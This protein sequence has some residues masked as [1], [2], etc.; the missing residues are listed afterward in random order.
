MADALRFNDNQEIGFIP[1]YF[2]VRFDTNTV[3][4]ADKTIARHIKG[5]HEGFQ[6]SISLG[7]AETRKGAPEDRDLR[8][9]FMQNFENYYRL[10]AYKIAMSRRIKMLGEIVHSPEFVEKAGKYGAWYAQTFITMMAR[11]GAPRQ[12]Q[13]WERLDKYRRQAARGI[14]P[15][16]PATSAIHLTLI[17]NVASISGPRAAFGGLAKAMKPGMKGFRPTFGAEYEEWALKNFATYRQDHGN[18]PIFSDF[19]TQARE[20]WFS[21]P[22]SLRFIV[23][24]ATLAALIGNYEKFIREHNLPFDPEYPGAKTPKDEREARDEDGLQGGAAERSVVEHYSN[25][26]ALN[27][28]ALMTRRAIAS[29]ELPHMFLAYNCG[30]VLF[31]NLSMNRAATMFQ[32]FK[33]DRFSAYAHDL[34]P[35]LMDPKEWLNAA[36]FIT[37]QLT[38]DLVELGI[39]NG[40]RAFIT[41]VIGG[42]AAEEMDSDT[43][44]FQEQLLMKQ[45]EKFPFA[46]E[47]IN[48]MKYGRTPVT[49]FSLGVD[50]LSRVGKAGYAYTVADNARALDEL[51][52]AAGDLFKLEGITSAALVTQMV[53]IQMANGK[54]RYPYYQERLRLNNLYKNGAFTRAGVHS[55]MTQAEL[56]RRDLLNSNFSYFEKMNAEYKACMKAGDRRSAAFTLRAMVNLAKSAKEK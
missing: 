18:D 38:S 16:L 25:Q 24:K 45:L 28:A 7:A 11:R 55:K 15:W 39:R 34:P 6:K 23:R 9:D 42:V 47:I 52:L 49:V 31:G 41:A 33:L 17:T 43:R 22:S 36:N 35:M 50:S 8:L 2:P 20:G 37:W 54:A 27:Y 12:Y 46:P 13:V 53:Q 21:Q 26:D 44:K 4:D 5:M 48:T 30:D 51:V 19:T 32:N 14:I 29:P 10:A 56:V 1:N 40:W 3:F